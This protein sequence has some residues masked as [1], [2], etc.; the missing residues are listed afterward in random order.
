MTG[1]TWTCSRCHQQYLT[2]QP[3]HFCQSCERDICSTCYEPVEDRCHP[4]AD[5]FW[6]SEDD[7]L[8]MIQRTPGMTLDEIVTRARA[9]GLMADASRIPVPSWWVIRVRDLVRDAVRSGYIRC[10]HGPCIMGRRD[11]DNPGPLCEFELA[12]K[13]RE[14][15]RVSA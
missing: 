10:A 5:A 2:T 12:D 6:L 14:F 7:V 11:D 13:G 15:F 9:A 4:C 3:I 8:L 1:P